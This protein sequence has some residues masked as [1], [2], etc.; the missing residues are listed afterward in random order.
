MSFKATKIGGASLLT[1]LGVICLASFMIAAFTWSSYTT[2]PRNPQEVILGTPTTDDWST[3]DFFEIGEVYEIELAATYNHHGASTISYILK[4][5]ATATTGN[6]DMNNFE[7][8]LTGTTGA[9][10]VETPAGVWTA[11]ITVLDSKTSDAITL[12]IVPNETAT[13]L[14]GVKFLIAAESV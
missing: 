12:S 4:V 3:H 7:I 2:S 8:T 5:T 14:S 6:I 11:S 1:A 9:T 13:G 10:L